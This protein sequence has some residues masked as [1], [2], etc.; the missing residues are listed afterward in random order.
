[1]TAV[2]RTGSIPGTSRTVTDSDSAPSRLGSGKANSLAAMQNIAAS[3][4]NP[5]DDAEGLPDVPNAPEVLATPPKMNVRESAG[6]V[7][8]SDRYPE[9]GGL[10]VRVLRNN[11]DA[12]GIPNVTA[13]VYGAVQSR[14]M[15][16]GDNLHALKLLGGNEMIIQ[17]ALPW[18]GES[19]IVAHQMG[20]PPPN[21]KI[22]PALQAEVTAYA[23]DKLLKME[24]GDQAPQLGDKSAPPVNAQGGSQGGT[25]WTAGAEWLNIGTLHLLNTHPAVRVLEVAPGGKQLEQADLTHEISYFA[26]TIA[27]AM[28][29]PDADRTNNF[30]KLSRWMGLPARTV[31]SMP[32]AAAAMARAYFSA[33]ETLL[34]VKPMSTSIDLA[35]GVLKNAADPMF[36]YFKQWSGALYKVPENYEAMGLKDAW[37]AG[38]AAK[39]Y[40][41][42]GTPWRLENMLGRIPEELRARTTMSVNPGD[43]VEAVVD[44][45]NVAERFGVNVR[46]V[47]IRA[48]DGRNRNPLRSGLER[49]IGRAPER[50]EELTQAYVKDLIENHNGYQIAHVAVELVRQQGID[51][52]EE[53]ATQFSANAGMFLAEEHGFA[54]THSL[55]LEQ[56]QMHVASNLAGILGVFQDGEGN[57]RLPEEQRVQLANAVVQNVVTS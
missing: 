50:E 5:L 3:M 30:L 24:L 11:P 48:H 54:T 13:D 4:S 32:I 45:E 44:S 37:D 7:D 46:K 23:I 17:V 20:V 27:Q 51:I 6:T 15:A 33:F 21:T 52:N 34:P 56:R 43:P 12:P 36:E 28:G 55:T 16:A 14:S 53:M 47:P 18:Q 49:A 25:V 31:W 42:T 19:I 10:Y 8:I 22:S 39:I 57:P 29:I 2:D 40:G 9:I 1:M 26:K 41:A 35:V 38:A